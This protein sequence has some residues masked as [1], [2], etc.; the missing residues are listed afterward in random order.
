M[1]TKAIKIFRRDPM[2]KKFMRHAKKI[3]KDLSGSRPFLE[4]VLHKANGN[5]Y[6]TNSHVLYLGKVFND[7][8]PVEDVFIKATCCELVE[9]LHDVYRLLPYKILGFIHRINVP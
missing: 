2:Y 1:N 6:A 4:G 5:L 3:T 8:P 7:N 9:K